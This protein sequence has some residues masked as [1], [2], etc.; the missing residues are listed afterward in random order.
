MGVGC[1]I[2]TVIDFSLVENREKL[3][4]SLLQE[5]PSWKTLCVDKTIDGNRYLLEGL[6]VFLVLLIFLMTLL[7]DH[8]RL[9]K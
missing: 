8:R 5:T 6:D 1:E 9:Q 7:I 4:F 2:V 3:D